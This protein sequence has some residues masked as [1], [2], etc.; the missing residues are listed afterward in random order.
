MNAITFTIYDCH[1]AIDNKYRKLAKQEF[2]F[3]NFF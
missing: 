1:I 2:A 3:K